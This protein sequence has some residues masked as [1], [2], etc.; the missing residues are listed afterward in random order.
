MDTSYDL[1]CEDVNNL[2]HWTIYYSGCKLIFMNTLAERLNQRMEELGMTQDRLA[3]LAKTSQTTIHKLCTGKAKESRKL[4]AIAKV[5]NV[6]P[7]Y[8]QFGEGDA[9][10]SLNQ[11][12]SAII[13][14]S[15]PEDLPLDQYVI[16]PRYDLHVAAGNGHV[17]YDE[18]ELDQGKAYRTDYIRA[19]GFYARNLLCLRALGDSM[20]PSIASGDTLLIDR[21][22]NQV[23]DR[24]VYV[25]RYGDEIR[26][27]RLYRRP[28]GGLRIVSDNPL[29]PEE[30]VTAAD[31]THIEIIGCVVERSG[32]M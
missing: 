2:S 16:V 19:E 27:K 8:L 25:L 29:Y 26:V 13:E 6:T 18:L 32:R 3:E 31:M 20:E 17:V 10:E 23:Q 5:L 15:K 1:S 9:S 14:W 21:S 24:K 12:G 11:V 4:T 28:D 7:K 30:I 22:Q